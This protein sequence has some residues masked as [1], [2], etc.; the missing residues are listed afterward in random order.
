M[1]QRRPPA[2]LLFL[3][4]ATLLIG[5]VW[6]FVLPPFQAPDEPAHVAYVQSIAE[7]GALPG[8][9]GR[10]SASTEQLD[11]AAAANSDQTAAIRA[12]KPTWSSDAYERWRRHEAALPASARSDGGGPNFASSN[13]PLYYVWSVLPYWLASGGDLFARVSAMRIGSVVFLLVTVA[14]TWLLPGRS[15]AHAA[16]SSSPRPPCPRCCRW[17]TS[18]RP[19]CR[20]TRCC[21]R[22]GRSACGSARVCCAGAADRS[23]W[24]R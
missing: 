16:T 8:A 14:A 9:A 23:T 24:S 11:G 21:T 1:T 22:S 15:S 6:T 20:R 7:R 4:A 5:I 18:S 2:P 12:T 13:P 19:R 3:L 10:P 17:S